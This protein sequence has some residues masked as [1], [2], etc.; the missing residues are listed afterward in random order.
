V[1]TEYSPDQRAELTIDADGQ[2]RHVLHTPRYRHSDHDNPR[3]AAIGYLVEAADDFGIP[4]E[5]LET[6]TQPVAFD[7]PREEDVRYRFYEVKRYFSNSTFAFYQTVHNVPIWGAGL[8]VTVKSGPNRIIHAEHRGRAD[9]DLKLPARDRLHAVRKA[10]RARRTTLAK[11]LAGAPGKLPAWAARTRVKRALFYAYR[12]DGSVRQ[13]RG[14]GESPKLKLPAVPRGIRR[15][16]HYLVLEVVFRLDGPGRGLNWKA[17]VEVGTGAIL[18]LRPMIAGEVRGLAFPTDPKTLTGDLS[19]DPAESNTVLDPLRADVELTDLDAPVDGVQS[20]TGTHVTIVDDDPPAV[21]APTQP[22]GTPTRFDYQ[23]RTNDFAAVS[24]YYHANNV[25]DTIESL[26]F[27][28]AT[29]FDTSV[30]PIHVDHRAGCYGN[31]T[32]NEIGAFCAGDAPGDAESG[33]GIGLIGYCLSDT[34]NTVEPL[35]RAVDKWTHWHEIGGHGILFDHVNSANFGFCHSAG[36]SLA[37]F[38]NDPDSGL[39]GVPER[40]RYG[41]FVE[42][43]PPNPVRMFNRPA[44]ATWR[45]GGTE[46]DGAYGTEQILATTLFRVYQA[47]GGD[48]ADLAKRRHAARV[49]TY[50][51]LNAVGHLTPAT[52]PATPLDF[53]NDLLAA[54]ADDWTTKGLAG[55]AYNKVLRWSFVKQGLTAATPAI[56]LYLDDGRGGE[57][58]YIANHWSNQSVWNRQQA[59]DTYGHEPANEDAQNHAYVRVKNRG[60]TAAEGVVRLYH[61]KPGAGLT[62]PTDFDQIGPAAGLPTGSVPANNASTATVGPFDWTPNANAYGHDCL[63]AIVSTEQDPS[64]VDNLEAGQTIQEWRLV[65]HDNNVGQ[66]NVVLVPGG[67]GGE[68][69]QGSLDGAPFFAGNNL[70][71]P[72]SMELRVHMSAPLERRGW[73]VEF[74]GLKKRRFRLANGE[75]REVR[76]RLVPGEDF[77]PKDVRKRSTIDVSLYGNGMLLGG[78]SYLVDPKLTAAASAG[79]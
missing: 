66:R 28:I 17:L 19:I 25:F 18:W 71:R 34:T 65:P 51:V 30:I 70:G 79:E 56:D 73:A 4:P 78:M 76:L 60:A 12:Y 22:S 74:K 23:A 67:G 58:Q 57:Y 21:A 54:D 16:N 52:N 33:D 47:L 15:G 31:P 20:L 6:L 63:L 64:N 45:W 69:L 13:V 8:T 75:T 27:P 48:A 46:D 43:P 40:F 42:P 38:Q 1:Q 24:A 39:R 37:A 53:L 41:P 29:Y 61:C 50:L 36:D 3:L 68:A 2:L 32:G 55:G 59:D 62:W 11:L 10:R 77:K 35:G 5:R 14:D 72:A 49:A 44:D 7:D 9:V 26:G